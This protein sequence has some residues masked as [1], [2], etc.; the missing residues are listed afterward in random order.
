MFLASVGAPERY[1]EALSGYTK[2][3]KRERLKKKKNAADARMKTH[4]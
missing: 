1:V 4:R 2:K 3:K